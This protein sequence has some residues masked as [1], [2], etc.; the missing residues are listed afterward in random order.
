MEPQSTPARVSQS[1]AFHNIDGRPVL[2]VGV[3]G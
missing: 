2:Y 1:A 3:P